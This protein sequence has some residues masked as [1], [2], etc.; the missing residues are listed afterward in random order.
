MSG[1]AEEA[2]RQRPRAD[3]PGTTRCGRHAS[4]REDRRGCY[5]RLGPP[6]E[7]RPPAVTVG[8]LLL[9]VEVGDRHSSTR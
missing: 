1:A 4:T 7:G 6:V 8:H 3:R 2:N 5:H 9:G